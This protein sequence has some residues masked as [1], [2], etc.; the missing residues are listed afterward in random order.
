MNYAIKIWFRSSFEQVVRVH[1]HTYPVRNGSS[2]VMKRVSSP[3]WGRLCPPLL[4]KSLQIVRKAKAEDSKIE[5]G[6]IRY[7]DMERVKT[8][9]R[10]R[11]GKRTLNGFQNSKRER[12]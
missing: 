10:W 7:P 3:R 2:S 6:L 4:K 8:E 5:N 11:L 1:D 9:G 12:R